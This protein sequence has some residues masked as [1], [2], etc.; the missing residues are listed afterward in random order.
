MV[1]YFE[2]SDPY[3]HFHWGIFLNATE[4]KGM[5]RTKIVPATAQAG[6]WAGVAFRTGELAALCGSPRT[7]NPHPTGSLPS[8]SWFDGWNARTPP[9]PAA[10]G[11]GDVPRDAPR[12]APRDESD[13]EMTLLDKLP[14]M[15]DA[16]L[17][18][19][20]ANAE[21]LALSGTP[22]QRKE[23]QSVLPAIQAE[24]SA[25]R[26]RKAAEAP[27]RPVAARRTAAKKTA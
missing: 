23:A 1:I 6:R 12:D 5:A 19:L 20:G 3:P 13:C 26:E 7:A 25:R 8:K 15:A 2:I 9:V 11:A 4:N 14:D 21:R 16:A 10:D 27:R 22:K 17:D 18:T 24:I